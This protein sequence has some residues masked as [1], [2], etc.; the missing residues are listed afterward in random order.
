MRLVA[1]AF[2]VALVLGGCRSAPTAAF[3]VQAAEYI[4]TQGPS[5]IDGHAFY[6]SEGGTVINAAGEYAYLIPVTQYAEQRIYQVFGK[7]KYIRA[8]F[9]P[10][11][12]AD[13]QFKKYMRSTKADS[14]GRF[15]F[16]KVAP[17]EYYVAATVTWFPLNHFLPEGAAIYE[18]VSVTGKETEPVKVIVSGK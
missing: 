5:R 6:R 4:N 14:T 12:D 2:L 3:D 8:K 11:D 9:L 16:D 1:S 15:S 10:W 7:G 17:G 13:P 18:R